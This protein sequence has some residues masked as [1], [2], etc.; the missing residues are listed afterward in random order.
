MWPMTLQSFASCSNM[1]HGD[2]HSYTVTAGDPTG[3]PGAKKEINK[4]IDGAYMVQYT[5]G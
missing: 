5:N 2:R 3:N 1:S 4:Y